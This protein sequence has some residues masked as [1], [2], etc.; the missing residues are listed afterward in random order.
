MRWA[1][2][3]IPGRVIH[4]RRGWDDDEG[5]Q[6]GKSQAADRRVPILAVFSPLLAEHKLA[7]GR[8]GEDLVF[9][10]EPR[11][12][13]IPST[14]RRRA[15]DAWKR[16]KLTSTSLHE[17][18]HTF[19]SMMIASGANPKVIQAVMGHATIEMTFDIYG[20]LMPGGLEEAAA[21]ADAYI[22]AARARRALRP[23]AA[24]A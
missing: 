10:R 17:A 5:E 11:E 23:Q 9:G 12:P 22:T 18:R 6:A 2:V 20:H 24:G 8:D 3:D 21:A 16:A 7:T 1:D 14:V 19:A 13:F 4:V 15:I